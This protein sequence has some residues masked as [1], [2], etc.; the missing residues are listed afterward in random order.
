MSYQTGT[1]P[2]FRKLAEG[3]SRLRQ[4][5][6]H[7]PGGHPHRTSGD[8]WWGHGSWGNQAP[9]VSDY[10]GLKTPKGSFEMLGYGGVRNGK[11]H[12]IWLILPS[13]SNSYIYIHKEP[14]KQVCRDDNH[15]FVSFPSMNIVFQSFLIMTCH[16]N[17]W[18]ISLSLTY[19]PTNKLTSWVLSISPLMATV[20]MLSKLW[21]SKHPKSW[22]YQTLWFW[23]SPHSEKYH[24]ISIP[25]GNQTWSLEKSHINWHST[26]TIIWNL[27]I[28][29]NYRIVF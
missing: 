20:I 8:V 18:D 13:Q 17:F 1:P 29:H 22:N 6:D 12:L 10:G 4:S 23:E 11:T 26:S 2:S 7:V 15:F 5:S 16:Y 21:V 14:C 19:S 24:E 9:N 27:A 28:S 25:L 3:R